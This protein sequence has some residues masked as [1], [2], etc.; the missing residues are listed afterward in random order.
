MKLPKQIIR[1]YYENNTIKSETTI[2]QEDIH[3]IS[4]RE[5]HE[6]G[7]LASESHSVNGQNVGIWRLWH[8]NGQL[9][10]ESHYNS[11][12]E[13][14]G[15]FKEWYENGQ[16]SN[17]WHYE[18]G[19][20]VGVCRQWDEKGQLSWENNYGNDKKDEISPEDNKSVVTKPLNAQLGKD[21]KGNLFVIMTNPDGTLVE[22]KP[23][24]K[25][26]SGDEYELDDNDV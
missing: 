20:E 6:N 14:I 8:N 10:S 7:Q 21:E 22:I 3:D 13:Q 19:K 11:Y 5:W 1:S 26:N 12:G 23:L 17:E 15:V 18:N 2:N 25:K 16:L 9:A 4:L 24:K